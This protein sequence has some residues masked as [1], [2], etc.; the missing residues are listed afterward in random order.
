MKKLS[1]LLLLFG[2]FL[3]V[4]IA[5]G[6]AA[7]EWGEMKGPRASAP[8]LKQVPAAVLF[9]PI[10]DDP[11]GDHITSPGNP[12]VDIDMVEGGT[13]G[14]SVTLKVHFSPDTVMSEVVGFIDL[15]TDQNPATGIPPNAN[16]FIPGTMQD[17]GVDF[18]L[19]L[20][21]LPF[22]GPVDVFDAITGVLV[23]SVP[24][25]IVGQSLEITVP[26]AML[27]GDDGAMDVGM[28][29][30]N[31]PQP[32]DAAPNVGHGAV[33]GG[34]S[35]WALVP[36]GGFTPSAPAATVLEN[37]LA[38]FVQGTDNRLYVNWLLTNNQ[39][40]GW[41]LVPGNGFTPSAPAATVLENE[42]ALFVRG[43][44]NRLYV[45][46]LLTNNQWTGWALVPGDGFAPSPPPLPS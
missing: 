15:D 46:W 38:L 13:N 5:Q 14:T 2:L 4:D 9:A 18:F 17:I 19:S 3:M 41:A 24:A 44:D 7:R 32:T 40:T 11:L 36:G 1:G 30:G 25:T 12:I 28:V 20:F 6:A 26:L 16:V 35:T 31:A 34:T 22:G 45:N 43:T 10:I 21:N 37:E 27:G 8:I 29:L 33:S 39:W 42:L 23:G